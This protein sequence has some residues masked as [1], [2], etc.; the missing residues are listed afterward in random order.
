MNDHVIKQL[1]KVNTIK[2]KGKPLYLQIRETLQ[3][4]IVDGRIAVG[5]QLPSEDD[6]AQFFGVSRMTVRHALG[7]LVGNGII[8]RVHGTGTI[9][10]SRKIVRNYNRLN[11]FFEDA[12]RYG[13]NPSSQLLERESIPATSQVAKAL[14][15]E[16]GTQV[17]HLT[18]LRYSNQRIIAINEVYTPEHLCPWLM[19][20]NVDTQSLYYLYERNGFK[21]EWGHQLIEARAA[22]AEQARILEIDPGSPVLYLERTTFASNDLPIEWTQAYSAPDRYSIEMILKR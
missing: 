7:D 10:A 11:S 16:V 9:V 4:L 21:L 2:H 6:L 12:Q 3:E 13:L 1:S 17:V 22:S 19:E 5:E 20:E 15:I 14:D 18:R 8:R